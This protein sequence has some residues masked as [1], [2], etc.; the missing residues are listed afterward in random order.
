[1]TS[2]KNF[3]LLEKCIKSFMDKI[4]WEFFPGL[5][6]QSSLNS[7]TL[8]LDIQYVG[9]FHTMKSPA[10]LLEESHQLPEKYNSKLIK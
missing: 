10:W 3:F 7:S 9:Y 4:A 6:H 1:M 2:N 5:M 8:I